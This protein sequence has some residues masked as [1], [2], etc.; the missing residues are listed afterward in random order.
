METYRGI[1]L[2]RNRE[3]RRLFIHQLRYLQGATSKLSRGSTRTPLTPQLELDDKTLTTSEIQCLSVV[4]KVVYGVV[5]TQLN[6]LW[7]HSWLSSGVRKR[8]LQYVEG[9]GKT[10]RYMR[11]TKLHGLPHNGGEDSLHLVM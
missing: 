10:V 9:A 2:V 3:A 11:A 5:S 1:H 8:S 7:A 6:L 4:G